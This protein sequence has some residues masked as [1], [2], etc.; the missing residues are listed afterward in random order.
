MAKHTQSARAVVLALTVTFWSTC[1]AGIGADQKTSCQS[2]VQGFYNW[3]V[4]KCKNPVVKSSSPLEIALKTRSE[5]FSPDLCKQ[6]K[7]DVGASAKSPGEI[8]GLDFDPILNSQSQAE[9]CTAD[10]VMSKGKSWLVDVYGYSGGK[11]GSA[12]DVQPELI[13]TNGKWQ[14]I[15]FHYKIDNKNDDLLHILKT[16]RAERKTTRK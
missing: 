8:V 16:L 7:E 10:K 15:N 1:Q 13:E 4:D 6:L 14:F 3:Y 9:R 12:P 2:F 11:K 5:V